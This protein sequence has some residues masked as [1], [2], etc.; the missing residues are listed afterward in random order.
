MAHPE[1]YDGLTPTA[2]TSIAP[3][4]AKAGFSGFG[5]PLS[6]SAITKLS[7]SRSAIGA[8]KDLRQTLQENE[9]Y[10]GPISGLQQYNPYSDARKA[11]AKIDLVKQRV[12]KALEGG[13]LRK[14]DEEKYKQILATLRDEP[15]TAITKVDQ[16][17]QSFERDLDTFVE[18][19]RRAGRKVNTTGSTA[20]TAPPPAAAAPSPAGKVRVSIGGKTYDFDS[21]AKAEAFKR[22]AA[23]AGH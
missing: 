11:Q 5:K 19:Q 6:E 4:L 1:L 23:A 10:I 2:K 8:L 20:V 17:I 16:V 3:E 13:V 7:D 22:A 15:T 12:G 14:E 9:R 21:A 18:E